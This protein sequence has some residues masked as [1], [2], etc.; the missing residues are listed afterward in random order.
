ML[1]TEIINILIT[2]IILLIFTHFKI[3][4]KKLQHNVSGF[5][6]GDFFF[7]KFRIQT[8]LIFKILESV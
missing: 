1:H 2:Q 3:K 6:S 8:S 4:G 7:F 5:Y